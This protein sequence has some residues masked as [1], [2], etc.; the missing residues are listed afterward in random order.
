MEMNITMLKDIIKDL[1][2]D[3]KV[4]VGCQGYSNYNFKQNKPCDETDTFAKGE[5]INMMNK[6][7]KER[8]EEMIDDVIQNELSYQKDYITN[9]GWTFLEEKATELIFE[10]IENEDMDEEE[11]AMIKETDIE[12]YL[13]DVIADYEECHA[14]IRVHSLW[15]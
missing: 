5:V 11:L 12:Q 7:L 4:F 6:E 1:P 9:D 2:D 15:K 10:K 3:M 8:I 14:P 13:A